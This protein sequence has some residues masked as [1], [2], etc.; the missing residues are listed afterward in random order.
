[1]GIYIRFV[2]NTWGKYSQAIPQTRK[3]EV[4]ETGVV[5]CRLT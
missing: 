3:A 5:V 1:M 2:G 4:G